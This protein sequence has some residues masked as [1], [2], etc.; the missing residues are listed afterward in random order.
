[1][2]RLLMAAIGLSLLTAPAFAGHRGSSHGS[3][4]STGLAVNAGVLTGKGGLVGTLLGSNGRRGGSQGILVNAN[5]TTG[6]NGVLGVLLGGGR[7]SGHH[8]GHG[9]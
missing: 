2:K 1:M 3:T 9:W 7:S 8:S 6:R 4:G 5:V